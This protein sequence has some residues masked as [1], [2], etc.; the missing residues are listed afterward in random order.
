[1]IHDPVARADT[2]D[3]TLTVRSRE[4]P[5]LRRRAHSFK[6]HVPFRFLYTRRHER[7]MSLLRVLVTL[8]DPHPHA[9]VS[10][11][12]TSSTALRATSPVRPRASQHRA[13]R[14]GRA[15]A[16]HTCDAPHATRHTSAS[17][18]HGKASS[19]TPEI[20]AKDTRCRDRSKPRRQRGRGHRIT[21]PTEPDAHPCHVDELFTVP[22][23]AAVAA[24]VAA[25]ARCREAPS[26]MKAPPA[27]TS[28][29]R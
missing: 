13:D 9:L 27:C 3:V 12:T 1:M 23:A 2:R 19:A 28:A 4:G 24:A 11:T 16:A 18:R 10:D 15:R 26:S 20:G 6:T 29:Q 7:C 25:A 21:A 17:G 8:H 22:P 14:A 5:V